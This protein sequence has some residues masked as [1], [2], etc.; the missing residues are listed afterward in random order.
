M[1]TMIAS[2]LAVAAT[3]GAIATA[4]TANADAYEFLNYLHSRGWVGSNGG[5]YRLMRLGLEVCE[6]IKSGGDGYHAAAMTYANTDDSVDRFDAVDFTVAAVINLCPQFD[7]R[8]SAV[9]SDTLA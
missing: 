4:G 9:R 3:T 2:G 7:H 1:K 5:D 8:G 6:V